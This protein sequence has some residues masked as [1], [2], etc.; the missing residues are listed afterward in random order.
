MKKKGYIKMW[1]TLVPGLLGALFHT[2]CYIL[3]QGT[4]FLNYH[5]RAKSNDSLLK[6]ENLPQ[7]T[8]T[9]LEEVM[10]I[11]DFAREEI[12]L[13]SSGN[14]TT[15]VDIGRDYLAEV[16]SAA[17]EFA[18]SHY[19][20]KFPI[21]G[22]VPYKGFFKHDDAIREAEKLKKKGYDVIIRK[23]DAF[24]SLGYF[25]DPLMSFMSSYSIYELASM[26][27]HEQFHS[28]LFLKNRVQFNEVAATFV[29]ET[30]A[31]LYIAEKYGHDSSEYARID[32]DIRENETFRRQII[33]LKD[34]LGT[35]YA[36]GLEP[37]IMRKEKETIVTCWKNDF[38]NRYDEMFQS[39]RYR[40]IE[41]ISINN[42]YLNLFSLYTENLDLFEELH[43]ALGDD[44]Q[45]TVAFLVSMN[46]KKEDPYE[47][48][49]R[50]L[51]V[52]TAM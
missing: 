7:V 25:K 41:K 49:K 29:G 17:P 28:T 24:S 13:K 8:R 40:S 43:Q 19:I 34:T 44:L 12:G 46:G 6:R 10:A 11:A 37:D 30:G 20:W 42:A 35:L 26:I 45:K 5:A 50:R 15:F 16:V 21:V 22:P 31:R 9:L 23:V 1:I 47:I 27:I 52:S 3:N 18:F 14:Y 2:G 39:D 32:I 4:Y 51:G 38:T 36:S 48:M 33:D